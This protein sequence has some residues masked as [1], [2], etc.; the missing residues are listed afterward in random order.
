MKI[1]GKLWKSMELRP[2]TLEIGYS[3]PE[4][5]ADL[6]GDVRFFVRG[7][8]RSKINDNSHHRTTTIIIVRLLSSAPLKDPLKDPL[9]GL[10]K[11][12]LRPESAG[13]P[14]DK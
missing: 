7:P 13:T 14:S 4:F 6:D 11:L 5:Y 9:K 3:R 10:S 2:R 12:S 1:D 8:F